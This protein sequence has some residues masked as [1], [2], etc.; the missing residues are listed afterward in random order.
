MGYLL[1]VDLGTTYTAGAVRT[2]GHAE[3]VQ[4]GTQRP[5][6]PSL[7]FVKLDGGLLVGEAAERRGETEPTR[8]AR[9][10]SGGWATRY[11]CESATQR[12]SRMR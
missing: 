10:S 6:I 7:V 4:L 12:S 8:L 11:P 5:E 2:N 1:A 3:V 9:E